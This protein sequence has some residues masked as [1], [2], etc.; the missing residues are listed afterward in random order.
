MLTSIAFWLTAGLTVAGIPLA[1][2]LLIALWNAQPVPVTRIPILR[3]WA[4]AF[5]AMTLAM[6]LQAWRAEIALTQLRQLQQ[7]MTESQRSP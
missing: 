1:L 7:Q 6:L 2:A 5:A 3:V 4:L